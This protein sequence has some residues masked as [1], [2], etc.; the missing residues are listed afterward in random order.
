MGQTISW[1][2]YRPRYFETKVNF[3]IVLPTSFFP[4]F[5]DPQI[6]GFVFQ[7]ISFELAKRISSV[8]INLGSKKMTRISEHFLIGRVE[9]I[10]RN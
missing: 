7:N 6:Y 3:F 9:A 8:K 10:Y 1:I 4:F 5:P 2:K